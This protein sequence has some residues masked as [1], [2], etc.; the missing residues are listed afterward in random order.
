LQGVG[1]EKESCKKVLKECKKFTGAF[2]YLVADTTLLAELHQM[3][4]RVNKSLDVVILELNNC[5]ADDW[6][7][8][9][10]EMEEIAYLDE[11]VDFDPVSELEVQFFDMAGAK[12]EDALSVFLMQILDRVEKAHSALIGKLHEL[13]ALLE[14]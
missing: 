5:Q 13:N 7:A 3:L 12:E 6:R 2:A 9:I 8:H 14:A 10:H 4:M 11:I 1:V